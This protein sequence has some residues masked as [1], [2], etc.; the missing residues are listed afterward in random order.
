MYQTSVHVSFTKIQLNKSESIVCVFES[1]LNNLIELCIPIQHR[2][3]AYYYVGLQVF[4]SCR[5]IALAV[6]S[7][8]RI[9]AIL[10]YGPLYC[11]AC[12]RLSL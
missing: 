1:K 9:V 8:Y 2:N 5:P 12:L 3:M 4:T 6:G 11:I 7:A 10:L